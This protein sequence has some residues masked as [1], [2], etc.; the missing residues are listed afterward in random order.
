MCESRVSSPQPNLLSQVR[1]NAPNLQETVWYGFPLKN[2][3]IKRE[4][5]LTMKAS[6]QQKQHIETPSE[7]Q[8][9]T[10]TK[11]NLLSFNKK[12]VIII[13]STLFLYKNSHDES[14]VG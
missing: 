10:N 14:N 1:K 9:N 11:K 4:H 2:T 13:C 8:D 3:W 5:L 12:T 7:K 6:K